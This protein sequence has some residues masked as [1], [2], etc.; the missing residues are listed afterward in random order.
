MRGIPAVDKT[1]L[2]L[3]ALSPYRRGYSFSYA[4]TPLS[5]VAIPAE[6]GYSTRSLST[7]VMPKAVPIQTRVFQY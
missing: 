2:F 4:S 1:P 3:V 6:T 5:G 7:V